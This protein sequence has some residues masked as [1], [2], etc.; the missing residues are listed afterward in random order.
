MQAVTASRFTDPSGYEL[1]TVPIPKA[2]S[3]S[4][5]VVRVRA[6]SVNPVD[7]KLANGL[8]KHALPEKYVRARIANRMTFK[9]AEID[10]ITGFLCAL[11]TM[12]LVLSQKLGA[13]SV[14]SK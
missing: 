7:V 8:F 13:Q 2:S 12:S 1:T 5:V 3:P 14:A 4:D 9:V 6:A 10:H 11:G